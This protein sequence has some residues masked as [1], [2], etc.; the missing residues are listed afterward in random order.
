MKPRIRIQVGALVLICMSFALSDVVAQNEQRTY[1]KAIQFFEK[2]NYV[3]ASEQLHPLLD[4]GWNVNEVSSYLAQCYFELH[5]PEKSKSIL[6]D[7]EDPNDENQYLL[8]LANYF[9][10]DFSTADAMIKEFD[11]TTNFEVEGFKQML[12]QSGGTY[13]RSKGYVIQNFGAEINSVD[14]EYSAVMYNDFNTLLFT[15]RKA[16][17]SRTD[18]DGL[19]YETIYSTAIDST[20]NWK[21]ASPLKIKLEQDRRHDATVQVFQKGKKMISYHDG[22]LFTST[23][24]GNEWQKDGTLDIHNE[25]GRDTHCFITEDES[26]IYFASDHISYGAQLDLFVSR[27]DEKGNWTEPEPMTAFNT[28]YDEDAPFVAKDG[29]F[30]FSSRGHGST[31]GYDVFK[32]TYDSARGIWSAPENLG[33]PINTVSE[34]IYYTTDGKLGYISSTRMG[35]YGSLDL[36]RIFLF[37]KVKIHGTLY[38]QVTQEPIPDVTIDVQYDSIFLRSYTDF[39]GNYE[40]FVPI[41]KHM[42]VTF[43]KDS[44]NLYEGDYIVNVFFKDMNNNEFN[45]QIDYSSKEETKAVS[46]AT[47]TSEI[48]IIIRNDYSQNNI[49]DTVSRPR[50]YEWAQ[51]RNKES[52]QRRLKWLEQVEKE[53]EVLSVVHFETNS[54][55]LNDE[56]KVVLDKVADRLQSHDGHVEIIGHTDAIGSDLTNA[57]LSVQRARAVES[58]LVEKGVEKDKFLIKGVGSSDPLDPSHTLEAYS[59]NRRVE[60][61]Y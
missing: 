20:N 15:S 58:Y 46:K 30:Y 28:E 5:Q 8:I 6:E 1:K 36:Y 51:I 37:N 56:S 42:K 38:D 17:G 22:Q 55:L 4:S 32:S 16:T 39:N 60:I 52:E 47:T 23:L 33:H 54:Y 45:F 35:G 49:I 34:D 14:R 9:T 40:M 24:V 48:P 59:K 2:G 50:E 12:A 21:K 18:R 27:K 3:E 10:E 43:V 31:G 26:T 25:E 13:S 61:N 19:D 11:D 53:E 57:R 7:L 29:T 41:N 44:L